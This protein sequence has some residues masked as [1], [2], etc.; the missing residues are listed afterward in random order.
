M[1]SMAGGSPSNTS[2]VPIPLSQ[3]IDP[4]NDDVQT[5]IAETVNDA[6]S[7][8]IPIPRS[9]DEL[10]DLERGDDMGTTLVNDEPSALLSGRGRN[11]PALTCLSAFDEEAAWRHAPNDGDH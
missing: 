6:P 2:S 9:S 7:S 4:Y 10:D 1:R 3:S 8:A 5:R 11:E